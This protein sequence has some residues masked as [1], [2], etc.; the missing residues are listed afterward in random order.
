MAAA[1][2]LAAV[3]CYALIP[4]QMSEADMPR[5]VF[6]SAVFSP[7]RHTSR[8]PCCDISIYQHQKWVEYRIQKSKDPALFFF[9]LIKRGQNKAVWR[10]GR[11]TV[12][13]SRLVHEP[14][15][16]PR[17]FHAVIKW[18]VRK[19]WGYSWG[20][21]ENETARG[22]ITVLYPRHFHLMVHLCIKCICQQLSCLSS[23]NLAGRPKKKNHQEFKFVYKSAGQEWDSPA[24]SS[25][26]K[27]QSF[28]RCVNSLHSNLLVFPSLHSF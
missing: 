20:A 14:D 1:S 7:R 12:S 22:V 26:R 6:Q 9:F 8:Q 2:G 18:I 19:P 24:P 13:M 5:Y 15:F 28:C 11:K 16:E 27:L 17:H 4:R 3:G 10:E 21:S 25:Q 23:G